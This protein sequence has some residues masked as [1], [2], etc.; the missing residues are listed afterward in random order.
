M[1][2]KCIWCYDVI[3][4]GSYCSSY[5]EGEDH[6]YELQKAEDELDDY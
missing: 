2:D 4:S 5:C 1:S 6:N 3:D